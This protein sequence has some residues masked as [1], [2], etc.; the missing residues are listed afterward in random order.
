MIYAVKEFFCWKVLLMNC[1][2]Q[3]IIE[4]VQVGGRWELE[5]NFQNFFLPQP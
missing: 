5:T 2:V 1:G 3:E 4:I